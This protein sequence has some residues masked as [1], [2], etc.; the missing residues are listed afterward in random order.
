MPPV[1]RYKLWVKLGKPEGFYSIWSRKKLDEFAAE[2]IGRNFYG[3]LDRQLFI[4]SHQED[5][6]QWLVKQSQRQEKSSR[7]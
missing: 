6:N 3:D 1:N 5:F 7:G 2:F 4:A